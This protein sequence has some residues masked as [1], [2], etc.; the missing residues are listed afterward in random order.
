MM[1]NWLLDGVFGWLAQRLADVLGWLL[2]ILTSRFFTSPD[3]TVL[4]QVRSLAD[5]SA[6]VVTAVFVVA[7][8][9]AAL[10][11]VTHGTFVTSVQVQYEA[12]TLLPRLAAGLALSAFAV[13]LCHSI[14]DL[15]NAVS[16]ALVGPAASG[17]RVVA[18][19]HTQLQAVANDP[20]ARALAAINTLIIVVLIFQLLLSWVTRVAVLLVVAGLGPVALACYALPQTQPV[21]ILWWRSLLGAL[22]TPALQGVAFSVGVDLLLD[23]SHSLPA[24][25]G[26]PAV[27]ASSGT[28]VVNLFFVVCL[29][30]L[31]VRIP[32]LVTRYAIR[33]GGGT[34]PAGLII[35]AV[36]VS[37]LTRRLPIPGLRRMAR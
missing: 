22:V 32:R 5:R 23:P 16:V 11:T 33:Q 20:A 24:E 30:L 17:P 21:A 12:K 7:I 34:N 31:A 37:T 27:T 36:V 4:P 19:V 2:S 14:I 1:T 35:R 3:V 29:L 13:P 18:F 25:A 9:V 26:F 10:L 6:G 28:T 8:L 15:A